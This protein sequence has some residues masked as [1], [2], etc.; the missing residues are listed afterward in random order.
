MRW[1]SA[2]QWSESLK[3]ELFLC[4]IGRD[5]S[6]SMAQIAHE[7]RSRF[8]EWPWVPKAIGWNVRP[9]QR[10]VLAC[11]LDAAISA[12]APAE[13]YAGAEI[14]ESANVVLWQLLLLLPPSRGLCFRQYLSACLQ[15]YAKITQLILTKF[16]PE[17]RE[18]PFDFGGN[19]NHVTLGFGLYGA[20]RWKLSD[21]W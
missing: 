1:I 14:C 21:T 13:E 19:P 8:V 11:F 9:W 5:R 6:D 3:E 20:V 4:I 18:K 10:G 7:L 12:A 16:G 17:P 2:E 15:D